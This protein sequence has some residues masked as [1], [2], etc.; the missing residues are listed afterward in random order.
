MRAPRGLPGH[1]GDLEPTL[2]RVVHG[3]AG[4]VGR[5]GEI[6]LC[7]T[8]ADV[9][10]QQVGAAGELQ[11]QRVSGGELSRTG[12]QAEAQHD[13]LAGHQRLA[14]PGVDRDLDRRTARDV[15]VA[16]HGPDGSHRQ[17]VELPGGV[18]PREPGD[19]VGVD[20]VAAEAHSGGDRPGEVEGLGDGEVEGQGLI[21]DL[22]EAAEDRHAERHSDPG[23]RPRGSALRVEPVVFVVVSTGTE[24]EALDFSVGWRERGGADEPVGA[25]EPVA[26]RRLRRSR[27][28][29]RAGCGRRMR[30]L[31]PARR[32]PAGRTGADRGSSTCG[33]RGW[34]R[35]RTDRSFRTGAG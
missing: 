11:A 32:T 12:R 1:A 10:A 2:P 33:R 13:R 28:R 17:V 18:E 27:C 25:V 14:A 19:D 23:V 35:S 8:L 9:A 21:G 6:E 16:G 7:V 22:V 5:D 30:A 3:V 15:L 20:L 29:R 24:V 26:H 31:H 4:Q 34:R